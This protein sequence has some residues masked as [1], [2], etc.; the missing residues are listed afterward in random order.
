MNMETVLLT[1]SF[2]QRKIN[3]SFFVV[4]VVVFSSAQAMP[5]RKKV[6]LPP[7]KDC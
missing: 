2:M 7:V 5:G 1:V 3:V 4:F 6:E